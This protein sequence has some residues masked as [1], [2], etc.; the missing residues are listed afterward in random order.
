MARQRQL[1]VTGTSGDDVLKVPTGATLSG[2]LFDG[3]RGN[4]TLDL[5]SYESPGV[6]LMLSYGYA[7]SNSALWEEAFTGAFTTAP[8]LATKVS[9]SIKNIE[10][11][12]GTDGDDQLTLF[13]PASLTKFA[14]GGPG[15][16]CINPRGGLGIGGTGSDWLVSYVA[17][18]T[19]V[20]GTYVDRVAIPDGEKDQYYLNS[21]PTIL[22]FEVGIDKLIFERNVSDI[23]AIESAVWESDGN[24]GAS[25]YVNGVVAVSL[26]GVSPADAE[27]ITF[28]FA[29]TAYNGILQGSVGDDMLYSSS[30]SERIIVGANS[31]H[32]L[33]VDFS[34]NDVLV[35]EGDG[36]LVWSDT[37]IN[38]QSALVGTWGNSSIT[39]EGYTTAA[40]PS[41]TME[42]ATGEYE[43]GSPGLSSWSV[44]SDA[45]YFL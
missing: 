40:V 20:G 24:G 6:R 35:F 38:G 14:D 39:L 4:D 5:S 33:V 3:G 31:G 22:D 16:D 7:K 19:L 15:D 36:L 42:S 21:A 13:T 44:A 11:V 10:S 27:T 41:L 37:F 2:V 28:G 25:L 26:A 30:S 8:I 12:I 18:N 17:G 43:L 34:M 29:L 23:P 45:D 1:T 9:G 32:D